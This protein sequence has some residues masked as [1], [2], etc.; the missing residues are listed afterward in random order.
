M[1]HRPGP[2]P[3]YTQKELRRKQTKDNCVLDLSRIIYIY[4]HVYI[5]IYVDNWFSL[6]RKATSKFLSIPGV[7]QHVQLST[8]DC[9]KTWS[10][11]TKVWTALVFVGQ[12]PQ[13]IDSDCFWKQSSIC[14]EI[15]SLYI[16]S[17]VAS[18]VEDRSKIQIQLR[19]RCS[20][21]LG[22]G[23]SPLSACFCSRPAWEVAC[24]L[25][26][27]T[28]KTKCI[29]GNNAYLM[30]DAQPFS[31]RLI[32]LPWQKNVLRPCC[33][34][35]WSREHLKRGFRWRSTSNNDLYVNGLVTRKSTGQDGFYMCLPS[36]IGGSCKWKSSNSVSGFAYSLAKPRLCF[37]LA[38]A[39]AIGNIGPH[40][41]PLLG[42]PCTVWEGL[43]Y[44]RYINTARG[45]TSREHLCW[46]ST[47]KQLCMVCFPNTDLN[48]L[49]VG[50]SALVG[51]GD[52][53]TGSLLA[54]EAAPD[55]RK[56]ETSAGRQLC[57][58]R[59]CA[60]STIAI[61]TGMMMTINSWI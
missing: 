41:C 13:F 10:T 45:S 37:P 34:I 52:Q 30:N 4:N 2:W 8:G 16:L 33:T 39:H 23:Q 35:C 5:Y 11:C 27:V 48:K 17:Q 50:C 60:Y 19:L 46:T 51:T 12:L 42:S 24:I 61:P 1:L 31:N 58:S 25:W 32:S 56:R 55:K 22:H 9:R 43:H 49:D 21:I 6:T 54:L 29:S 15:A 28:S 57:L 18:R 26:H 14:S 59:N 3:L 40:G 7:N 44:N 36:T 38:V 47:S 53:L 20:D